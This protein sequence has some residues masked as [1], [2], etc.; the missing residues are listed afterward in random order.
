MPHRPLPPTLPP[1]PTTRPSEDTPSHLAFPPEISS[2]LPGSR[3]KNW[4]PRPPPPPT[5]PPPRGIPPPPAR[6]PPT[7][8]HVRTS[9][10]SQQSER[11]SRSYQDRYSRNSQS[12]ER[13][14]NSR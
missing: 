6:P 3:S 8:Q 14:G 13:R 4:S 1:R 2:P 5:D 12:Y 9:I 7:Y 11:H 10:G